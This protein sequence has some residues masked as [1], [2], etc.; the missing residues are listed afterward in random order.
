MPSKSTIGRTLS[1]YRRTRRPP[2]RVIR[3]ANRR[4]PA[5]GLE[6]AVHAILQE[7][8]IPFVTEKTIGQ[9]HADIFISPRTVIELNGCYWHGH[10]T[11][12]KSLSKM[13]LT[14]LSSDARR[15]AFFK[16]LGFDV[17]VIWECEVE[18]DPEGVQARLAEIYR[19]VKST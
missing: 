11:C 17:H 2:A 15:Y 9:L 6:K 19:R 14:A 7:E 16:R 8:K 10:T 12:N 1:P 3:K 18:R 5:S 4:R 13:Q